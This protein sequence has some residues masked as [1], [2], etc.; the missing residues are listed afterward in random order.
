[1]NGNNLRYSRNIN[2]DIDSIVDENGKFKF[3]TYN[4]L[5]P[6]INMLSAYKPLGYRAPRWFNNMRL[7]EWEAFQLGNEQFFIFGAIYTAKISAIVIIE[8][9]DK[10]HQE[11]ISIYKFVSPFK[12]N[13]G[14]GMLNSTTYY[15]TKGFSMVI[16]NVLKDDKI[17]ININADKTKKAPKINLNITAY[18]IN[19]PIV[20]CMPLG[21]NRA[22]YSHKALMPMEG[23]LSIDDQKIQFKEGS[24]IIIDDHKG[25]YPYR[26][27]Y[28]WITGW[29]ADESGNDI[30]FNLTDN[31]VIDKENYNE[32]CLW[33]NGKMFTLPPIKV[34]RSYDKKEVWH[35]KDK[36]NTVDL[37]FYPE[38]KS[39][40][41]INA[42]IVY[43]DYEAP[44][45][46]F[47][48]YIKTDDIKVE[49]KNLFGMG[50]KKFYRM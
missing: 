15:K 44:M 2:E 35:I 31:Q 4:N 16:D 17:Q 8:I 29:G 42:L 21:E 48:G 50:E 27:K 12:T 33:V 24:H 28:D 30:G 7:K 25:Y 45:G 43:C 39:E 5:I 38:R 13:I 37:Y 10:I 6:N 47:E 14:N 22:I 18:H 36:Y 41:K 23:Y 46:R 32:N 40:L 9:Y 49:L 19:E 1:M 26:L 11:I 20:T 3:G 34:E